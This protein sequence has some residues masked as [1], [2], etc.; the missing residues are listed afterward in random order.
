MQ[1]SVREDGTALDQMDKVELTEEDWREQKAVAHEL[2]RLR[3]AAGMSRAELAEKVGGGFT[4]E[5]VTQYEDGGTTE[6]EIWPVFS[7]VK[8]LHGNMNEIDPL[9]LMAGLYSANGYTELNDESRQVADVIIHALLSQ[10]RQK[11]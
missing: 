5:L 3:E 7:M 1:E 4:E 8:V 2:R 11:P 9:R 10:Q 6:M